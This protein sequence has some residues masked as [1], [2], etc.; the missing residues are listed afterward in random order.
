MKI[1]TGI[2]KMDELLE[3]GIEAKSCVLILADPLVDVSTFVQQIISTRLKEEDKCIYLLTNKLPEDVTKNMYQHGFYLNENLVFIDCLSYTLQKDTKA[4]YRLEKLITN[5]RETWDAVKKLWEDVLR[6]E[7]GFKIAVWDCLQT[8]MGFVDEIP[9]FIR[10]CK[11]INEETRTTS[12]FILTNWGYKEDELEKIKKEFDLVIETA[13]ITK[14]LFYINYYKI[15][16]L[17]AVPFTITMTGVALYV[18]KILVTGPFNAGKS[19]LVKQ[20]SEKSVSIDRL[21]TTIALDHG[22]V[23]KKGLVCNLFGTPG[24]ERFDWIMDVLSR[25]TWGVILI[26][27]STRPETFPRA[28]QMLEKVKK[29]RIPFVVFANKQDLENALPPEEVK[30]R[31]GAPIVIG[32]SALHGINTEKALLTLFDEILKRRVFG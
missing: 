7:E 13:T 10:K 24:Q 9:E 5:G 30:K 8:F 3:G 14:K 16:D 6:N 32:G 12:I 26:V 27:D 25:D 1:E 20:L 2:P 31:L 19:T 29:E 15:D 11:E 4:K 22:Y 28:L 17:P 23:E 18:P 21:G